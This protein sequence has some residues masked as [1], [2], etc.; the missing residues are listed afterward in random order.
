MSFEH[1]SVLYN[2]C[3]EG[4]KIKNDGIYVD[5]TLGG[6]GHAEGILKM[7]P[8]GLLIGIDQ[9]PE[10]LKAATDRLQIYGE[11]FKP[12]RSNFEQ[13]ADVL[14]DL[15]IDFIDGMLMD[16]GVS[17]Y[18]L[19]TPERG[20]SY[21]H[22]AELDMRMDPS[23]KLTAFDVINTYTAKD[24]EYVIRDYGEENWAKRIV[25]FIIEARTTAPIRTTHQL[26][27]I[28]KAA[29]PKK[30]RMDGPHPAKRTF[31]AIRIE[32][33][34]EL[35]IIPITIK[36]AAQRLKPGGRL[37]IITFHS[38]EDRL[39]KNAFRDLSISC[40]CPPTSPICT[41]KTV[42]LLKLVTRKPI[43]PSGLEL[44]DN[45]RARSAKLRVAEKV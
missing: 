45:P 2:E 18:Q 10:A 38:L 36:A 44:L 37:A 22:D 3:L 25:A 33:N 24:L 41:C 1:V 5:G 43:V 17:S 19:D 26:V 9:D 20:F 27:D 32:V 8:S 7:L 4:L 40:I 15:K 23:A 31:Q 42:P 14:D 35:D 28:I 11:H 21:N 34:R 6:G 30:A 29:I 13:I 39:V 16:L 12:Y